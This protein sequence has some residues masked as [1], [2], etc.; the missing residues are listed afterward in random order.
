[1]LRLVGL[2][3]VAA[4]IVIAG[5]GGTAGDEGNE[6]GGGGNDLDRTDLTARL[7]GVSVAERLAAMDERSLRC[8]GGRGCAPSRGDSPGAELVTQFDAQLLNL[9]FKCTG[10]GLGVLADHTVKTQKVLAEY[11]RNESLIRIVT[12]VNGSIPVGSARRPC[13]DAF[14]NYVAFVSRGRVRDVPF[15]RG[16]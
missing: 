12:N 15:R 14:D 3:L 7:P 9:W 5:C 10:E 6:S 16:G 2:M 13:S 4:G 8:A 11:G 1:V